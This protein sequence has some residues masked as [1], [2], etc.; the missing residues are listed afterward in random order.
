MKHPAARTAPVQREGVHVGDSASTMCTFLT[1]RRNT[2]A[3]WVEMPSCL[4]GTRTWSQDFGEPGPSV[5]WGPDPALTEPILSS[6]MQALQP[7]PWKL[8]FSLNTGIL[9]DQTF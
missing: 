8:N 5:P 7:P 9:L 1:A 3:S 2:W 6:L 4:L